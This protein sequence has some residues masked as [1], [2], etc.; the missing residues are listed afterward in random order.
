ML[1]PIMDA[2]I[3]QT[4]RPVVLLLLHAEVNLTQEAVQMLLKLHA[5][6]IQ[7]HRPVLLLLRLHAAPT[8]THGAVSRLLVDEKYPNNNQTLP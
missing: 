4:Q 2:R 8:R 6:L 7:T 3:I 5:A 1:L